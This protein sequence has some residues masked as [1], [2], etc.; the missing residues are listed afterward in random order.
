M[1]FGTDQ[2]A[3]TTV[4]WDRGAG[5]LARAWIMDRSG[6]SNDWAGCGR[7][8]N[9]ARIEAPGGGPAGQGL[10]FPIYSKLSD[11]DVLRAYVVAVSAICGQSLP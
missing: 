6:T 8:L 10:D 1:K 11:K 4:E 3:Q 9:A 7:Y 2:K 5:G